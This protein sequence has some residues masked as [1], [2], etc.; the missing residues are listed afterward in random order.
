MGVSHVIRG[1]DHVTNT[2]AQIALFRALGAEPPRFGH[3]NLLTAAS[4]EG[5][6][7]RTGA[8]SIRSLRES[9]I[10][11]M[12]VAS[13]A[14]LVGT[15][16]SVAPMRD[17]DE[18]AEKFDIASASK[19]A[20]KFDPAELD[21]LNRALIHEMPFEEAQERLVA[22]GIDGPRAEEFWNAVRGNLSRVAEACEWW[23]IINDGPATETL[24]PD[25][26]AFVAAAFDLLPPEPWGAGTWKEWTDVVKQATGRKGRALFAPLRLALTG[27]ESGPELAALLPLMGREGTLARRP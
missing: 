13:L 12:A 10:E 1:D 15:S 17:M 20:A 8:L 19:S 5:L 23:S 16:E 24:S 11:P 21:V 27:R 25:D 14:V 18:L 4:G 26:K 22:M 9:R 3:H 2:G 7:K 6:S